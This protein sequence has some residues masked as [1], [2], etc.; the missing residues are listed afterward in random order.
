MRPLL[1]ALLVLASGAAA[2]ADILPDLS[3]QQLLQRVRGDG[4]VR[5]FRVR[6]HFLGKLLSGAYDDLPKRVDVSF[7]QCTIVGDVIAMDRTIDVGLTFHDVEFVGALNVKGST[8][9]QDLRLAG[10]TRLNRLNAEGVHFTQQV[11]IENGPRIDELLVLTGAKVGGLFRISRAYIHRIDAA[12]T[13]FSGP[14]DFSNTTFGAGGFAFD[15]GS[16]GAHAVFDGARVQGPF[17]LS[18][19]RFEEGAWFDRI[20]ILPGAEMKIAN[21]R[22]GGPLIF[23]HADILGTLQLT[24]VAVGGEMY[25]DHVNA[26]LVN[27]P[28]VALHGTLRLRSTSVSGRLYAEQT[29]LAEMDGSAR[30]S[31]EDGDEIVHAPN[32]FANKVTFAGSRLGGAD[33]GDAEFGGYVDFSDTQVEES[34]G[35]AHTLFRGDVTF[36]DARLPAAGPA[37]AAPRRGVFCGGVR[38][39]HA[40]DL[41]YAQV[42]TSLADRDAATLE[43]LERQFR[44]GGD[45][46]SANAALFERR[47][48]AAGKDEGRIANFVSRVFWGYGVR[49]LR[50]LFWMALV[51]VASSF[52]YWTQV[53]P[54]AGPRRRV[55]MKVVAFTWAV[56]RKPGFGYRQAVTVPFKALTL[57]QPI[58]L[59]SCLACFLYA[60]SNVSP[61]LNDL[62]KKLIG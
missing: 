38:F 17:T 8:F 7:L 20:T 55:L 1:V 14:V 46:A 27:A 28:W 29:A 42:A 49:P 13:T 56:W 53:P 4:V 15:G 11:S 47:R 39:E 54:G 21:T 40:S 25:L 43:T 10:R 48:L 61:L 3:E 50:V 19:W 5:G 60:L 58:L 32:A 59:T 23:S 37:G 57:A 18:D 6:G 62:V 9:T 12:H 31:L 24:G 45:L 44:R 41:K 30:R 33:F 26:A 34:L 35:L 52:A 51:F 16:F 36:R 2:R 22:I